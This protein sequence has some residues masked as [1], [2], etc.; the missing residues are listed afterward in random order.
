LSAFNKQRF[1]LTRF[2][3]NEDNVFAKDNADVL[4]A[5]LPF[6]T[7]DRGE[8]MEDTLGFIKTTPAASRSVWVIGT[9]KPNFRNKLQQHGVNQLRENIIRYNPNAQTKR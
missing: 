7:V 5:I 4:I 9:A 1:N 6:D 8:G 2:V 3:V